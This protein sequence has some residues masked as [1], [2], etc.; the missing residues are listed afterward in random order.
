MYFK[1]LFRKLGP[2]KSHI[3]SKLIV[4][5]GNIGFDID[6]YLFS[7]G[8]KNKEVFIQGMKTSTTVTIGDP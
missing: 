1:V 4:G 6:R 8:N 2:T 5:I 7:H 3:F